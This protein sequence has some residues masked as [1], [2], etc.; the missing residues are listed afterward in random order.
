LQRFIRETRPDVNLFKDPAF[1]GFQ[2]TLDGELKRLRSL[3]LGVKK[4]QAEPISIEEE[5]LLWE[6]GLLGEGNPQAL[7]D[8]VLFLCGIHF[9]L[10]SGEEHRSLQLAQ[11]ELVIPKEGCAHLIYTENYSKNNQGGLQHR[12]VKPKC[13][14]CFANEKNPERCLV[15]LYQVYLSHRP[16]DVK[17]F[18]LT[19]LR[20]QKGEIWYSKVPVGHNTLSQ[21]VGRL[22]KQAGIVGFKTN[23]SL[24]VTSATR[25]FQSGV[26]EQLIMSH[27]GHRSV[28]GVRFYKRISEE[29]KKTVSG[30]LSSAC[31]S[32]N[33]KPAELDP[34]ETPKRMKLSG[35]DD[36]AVSV[37]S[38]TN[39]NMTLTNL[40][41]SCASCTPSFN[42]TG[43]S[44]VTINYHMR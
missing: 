20:K 3:G 32:V 29:Q 30:I 36:Q 34:P 39:A 6:R 26:D 19:P 28:D 21:T 12:K 4:K 2:R 42:F 11:F 13:V 31:T 1:A 44:S 7:L 24:R 40:G 5:N 14:T 25:L 17:P 23:H 33:T 16:A 41:S 22:C 10:R 9:A 27:T 18:Y 38:Q 43:C 37:T 15:R 8:T 35:H